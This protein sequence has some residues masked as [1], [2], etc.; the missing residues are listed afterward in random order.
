[1]AGTRNSTKTTP[2]AATVATDEW[3]NS[4]PAAWADAEELDGFDLVDKANLVDVPFMITNVRFAVGG[5]DVHYA[6]IDAIY[7]NGD[8][9][10]FHDSSSTGVRGMLLRHCMER[11]HLDAIDTASDIPMKLKFVNGLRVSKYLR[12]DEKGKMRPAQTYYLTLSGKPAKAPA[13]V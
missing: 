6:Y 1:M 12:E 13:T 4:G 8:A 2:A 3:L 9:F 11:G 10:S 5:G 7:A